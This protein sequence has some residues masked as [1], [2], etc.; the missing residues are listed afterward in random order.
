MQARHGEFKGAAE[1]AGITVAAGTAPWFRIMS[2]VA[3]QP[4]HLFKTMRTP[5]RRAAKADAVA[6]SMPAPKVDAV[7]GSMPTEGA[8]GGNSK[9]LR[10]FSPFSN[11]V[12]RR[13]QLATVF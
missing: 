13:C 7:A 8:S 3:W 12:R 2:N 11:I 6:G 10:H 5:P 9:I 4:P 1:R